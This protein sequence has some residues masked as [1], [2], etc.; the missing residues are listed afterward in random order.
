MPKAKL[1]VVVRHAP[2]GKNSLCT[3]N[4]TNAFI[5]DKPT[6]EDI[7]AYLRKV[8]PG[9]HYQVYEVV[10]AVKT[11]KARGRKREDLVSA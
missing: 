9:E 11:P 2:D 6:A 7:A 10:Q 8:N 5:G 1:H 4:S 3:R